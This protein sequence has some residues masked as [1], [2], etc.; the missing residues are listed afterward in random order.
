MNVL[1]EKGGTGS[2]S[3]ALFNKDKGG[4][5]KITQS[6]LRLEGIVQNAY[7]NIQK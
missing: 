2:L 1:K 6:G 3:F 5:G 7:I 4:H